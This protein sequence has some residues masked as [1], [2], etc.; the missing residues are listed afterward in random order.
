MRFDEVEL[1]PVI[2]DTDDA[3]KPL[4]LAPTATTSHPASI[5]RRCLA[6]LTDVSLFVALGLALS[7]LLAA[8]ASLSA[9]AALA[10]FIVLVSFYYFV[11]CWMLWGK[12][13][14]GAIFDV[15]VISDDADALSFRAAAW[16][17]AGV[18]FALATLGILF[19]LPNRL[20][21]T[22]CIRSH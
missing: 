10:A 8:H 13:I 4:E 6:L 5:V 19:F 15:R 16:R 7:P 11:G 1:A 14:G 21:V 17:W 18:Y 12:T 20:S 9:I 22:R 3:P 2:F